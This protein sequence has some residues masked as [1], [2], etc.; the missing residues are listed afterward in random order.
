MSRSETTTTT[1]T[2]ANHTAEESST[3]GCTIKQQSIDREIHYR[4]MLP[5]TLAVST[6][7]VRAIGTPSYWQERARRASGGGT[8]GW[9]VCSVQQLHT[10]QSSGPLGLS[11]ERCPPVMCCGKKRPSRGE[12]GK[13]EKTRESEPHVGR[14]FVVGNQREVWAGC[15]RGRTGATRDDGGV[16]VFPVSGDKTRGDRARNK[17]AKKIS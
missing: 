7:L 16:A 12:G 10:V 17:K 13:A 2:T 9:T 1:T 15:G 5:T 14:L 4:P 3:T 6:E 8:Q 11:V